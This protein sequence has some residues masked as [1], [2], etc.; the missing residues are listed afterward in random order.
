VP[1]CLAL[2]PTTQTACSGTPDTWHWVDPLWA[3]ASRQALPGISTVAT[4][5][6]FCT[7]TVCPGVIGGLVT[8]FDASHMTATY[9]RTVAP[10]IDAEVLA[11]LGSPR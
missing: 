2:H 4:T 5:R 10:F 1:D 6:F 7:D 11:A 9:A 8:Y 3:A